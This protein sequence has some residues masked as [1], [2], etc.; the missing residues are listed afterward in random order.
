MDFKITILGSGAAVPTSRRNPSAQ[1]VVCRDRHILID[2]AEGTQMRLRENELKFQ[3]IDHVLISHLHGDHFFGL[4]G[5]LSTMHLLGRK[6]TIN[7]YAPEGLEE[8]VN[9]Q[10]LHGGARFGYEINFYPIDIDNYGVLF[11]DSQ[12]E[13]LH[14]PL[15]HKIPTSGFIVRE[16]LQERRLNVALAQE[17]G[18][19][20]ENYHRLKKGEDVE[21]DGKKFFSD[22][23]TF[24]SPKPK[25][26]AYCSDTKY[27]EVIIPFIS[28]VDL[29]YHEATFIEEHLERA[30]ST[31]HSTAM[32]AAQIANKA[33]VKRLLIGHI[34]ARYNS[35]DEHIAEAKS[36]FANTT[37]VEDNDVF[38]V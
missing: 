24:P 15:S 32:Q 17:N 34:S 27:S 20:I 35:V 8:I 12:I 33:R 7:I 37:V 36:K 16:K 18:V 13:L 25:A 14:F 19:R 9:I 5:L 29:L 23:Y 28:E 1:Y 26:Y 31:K 38:V 3:K 6:R 21:Q 30:T 2:C 4:I 11:E 22:D 10:L